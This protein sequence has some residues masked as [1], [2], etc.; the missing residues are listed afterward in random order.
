[1]SV[2]FI[3]FSSPS[4]LSSWLWSR[5]DSIDDD[6][7]VA[8]VFICIWRSDMADRDSNVDADAASDSKADADKVE[9]EAD[10]EGEVNKR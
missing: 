3:F 8:A 2:I 5:A 7:D 4:W 9:V 6:V 1:M 10:G